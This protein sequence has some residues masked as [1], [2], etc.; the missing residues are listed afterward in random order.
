M[1]STSAF[2]NLVLSTGQGVMAAVDGHE[3]VVGNMRLLATQSVEH[4]A[5]LV[6]HMDSHWG[7]QGANAT[8]YPSRAF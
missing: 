1:T 2:H 7:G 5:T 6:E 4:D 3:V 8:H